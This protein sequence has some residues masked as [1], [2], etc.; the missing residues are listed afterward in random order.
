MFRVCLKIFLFEIFLVKVFSLEVFIG[1]S[2]FK[3]FF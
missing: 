2:P 1:E 3:M